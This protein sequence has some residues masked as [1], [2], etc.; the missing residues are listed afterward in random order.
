[1]HVPVLGA[2][3]PGKI[4]ESVMLSLSVSDAEVKSDRYFKVPSHLRDRTDSYFASYR[5]PSFELMETVFVYELVEAY[6]CPDVDW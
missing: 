6:C 3:V 4:T 2:I 1:M 5:Y